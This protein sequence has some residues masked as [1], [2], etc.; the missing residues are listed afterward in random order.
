MKKTL[1]A[2]LN[3]WLNRLYKT[4]AV[5]L[6][7]MAVLLTSARIFLPHAHTFKNNLED[8]I[9]SAYQGEIEI[10]ELSAGWHKFGPTLVVKQV[11][12]SD[13]EAL[14]VEI[15][16]IDIGLD[17]WGTLKAQQIKANN[18]TLVGANIK[19]DQTVIIDAGTKQ[20]TSEEADID[21]FS[22]LI[23][24]QFKRFSV[25]DSKILIKTLRRERTILLNK[26]AW[27]N[28]GNKHKGIGKLEIE[29]FSSNS[30]KLLIDL[31]GDKRENLKGQI[32]IEGNNINLAPWF[33]KHLKDKADQFSTEIN[34]HSWI[35]VAGGY[36][37]DLHINLGENT[38]SWDSF[39]QQHV[40][41]IPQGNVS[42]YR[43]GQSSNFSMQTSNIEVLFNETP[44][45]EFQL[46]AT[47][48]PTESL[49]NISTVSLDNLWQLFPV[50]KDNFPDFEKYSSLQLSGDLAN[51]QIR[52][53]AEKLQLVL[54]LADVGWN[55]AN[56]I[57]GIEQI[58][59]QL[60]FDNDQVQLDITSQNDDIDFD[61]GFS[62]PIP[63]NELKAT[64]KANWNERF[65]KLA[66]SDIFLSSDE[67]TVNGNVQYLQEVDQSGVLS[68]YAYAEQGDASKAQ[69]YLPLPIMSESL[70]DYL[71]AA[72]FHG[73]VKQA[74]VLFNGPVATFPFTDN[75]GIFI[76]DADIEQA[77]YQFE[78]SWPAIE[79]AHLNLNFT[80]DSMLI[81]AYDGDLMG[82]QTKDL[83]VGIE[84]LS[85]ESI[86]TVRS[87]VDTEVNNVTELMVASPLEHSVGETLRLI[88]PQGAVTGTFSLD[89]PLADTDKVVAKGTIDFANNEVL[90]QAPEMNFT[91][92][93]GQLSFNNELINTK[94]ITLNWRGLPISLAVDGRIED[95]FYQVD[96]DLLANWQKQSYDPQIPENLQS[97]V[98]GELEWQ[99][100]L[101]LFIPENG[102]LSYD[103]HLDSNLQN[104]KLSLPEPYFKPAQKEAQLTASAKGN[105]NQST[106][107]ATLD[108]NLRFYGEL[109]HQKV[110]FMRTQ[111]VLGKEKILLPTDGFHIT[112][113]LD[114]IAY[115][116]WHEFIFDII[117]SIPDSSSSDNSSLNN[118]E[119]LAFLQAPER[120]RGNVKNIDFF[121]QSLTDVDFNLLHK[122]QWW[123]LQL[124]AEQARSRMKFYHDFKREGLEIDADFIHL[125]DAADAS[126]ENDEKSNESSLTPADIP[127]IKFNCDSC[128]YQQFDFGKVLFDVEN[129]SPSLVTLRAFS[130]K[131]KNAEVTFT[132]S[133]QKDAKQDKTSISG[134]LN[135]ED[136][137]KEIKRFD[138]ESGIK[139]SG[140]KSSVD[141]DWQGGPHQFNLAS[142]NGKYKFTFDDGYLADVSDKGA[143][144]LSIFSFQSLVRKLTLDFRDIFSKGMFYD[145]IKGTIHLE[146]GVAY[147][148]N[149]KM[150]GAAGNLKVKGNTNLVNNQL[151]Y[152]MS[153]A[154]KVTSSLPIIVGWLVNPLMGAAIMVADEAI[155]KAEVISVINFELTGTVDEPIFKEVDRKSRDVSVGKSKPDQPQ[156][157]KAKPEQASLEPK[158]P[159]NESQP[160]DL[161]KKSELDKKAVSEKKLG[162]GNG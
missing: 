135:F 85:G 127:K 126:E 78:Q 138:M 28:D 144:L 110:A 161:E 146:N 42:I 53:S 19:I 101:S 77:K 71:T 160:N 143:R 149:T 81:T 136:V 117:N 40:L 159:E 54:N 94:D 36:F 95:D 29:G 17:F 58:S 141:I 6:V 130:A 74:G 60:L 114:T 125:T 8:Y 62:R 99:G 67:L 41:K 121:G 139:D 65:W 10:G 128:K 119:K 32:Y 106:I 35:N 131:R 129:T 20:G 45:T 55:A 73:D 14:K 24:N 145:D 153:F 46:Q 51:I 15:E 49:T 9:N 63:F 132:G 69:Y 100:K 25:R 31:Q 2:Y 97:Y 148:D 13:S 52:T 113:D 151:D 72:I 5:L 11:I 68:L 48:T 50:I 134:M 33:D 80:N 123:L 56:G 108:D 90:L 64:I 158:I 133:W 38:F 82:I 7:L 157:D 137:E 152:K 16:E 91:Q 154:P 43:D 105:A 76:V 109:D 111:L 30:A 150:N 107:E 156:P 44:W 87:Q 89:L 18:F 88:N 1:W 70:V 59:G 155:Q 112:T 115:G 122:E 83:M 142:L 23:L 3:T 39:E 93:N 79:K 22:D 12:L 98:N 37:T 57:P 104:A 86:L 120:I 116:P 75:S 47:S 102:E 61:G 103:L 4:L 26:L 66:V 162:D 118:E 124:N 140:L 147:T 84:S 34:F 92:V 21:A 96:I 27:H